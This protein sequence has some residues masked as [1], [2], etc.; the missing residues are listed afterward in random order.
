MDTYLRFLYEFLTQFFSGFKIIFKAAWEGLT[1]IFDIPAYVKIVGAYKKDFTGGEWVGVAL[2]I[3]SIVA[4]L[5]LIGVLLFFAIKKLL[6]FR[7]K[8]AEREEVAEE[9]A[10]LNNKVARLVKEK[11]DILAM[12]V[13]QLGLKAGESPID[14]SDPNNPNGEKSEEEIEGGNTRFQKL[15]VVDKEYANYKIQN[16]GNTFNLEELCQTFR[17]FAA[18]RMKLYYKINIVRLFIPS[19]ISF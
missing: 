17:N 16:Y 15:A 18:S 9:I 10:D 5:G 14:E 7:K 3:L 19:S 8:L 11:Q 4:I 12:K 13:S 6:K 1:H 2:A